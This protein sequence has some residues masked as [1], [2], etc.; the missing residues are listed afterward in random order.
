MGHHHRRN[1]NQER[2]E[3]DVA[4]NTNNNPIG[5]MDISS[6]LGNLNLD[7]IDLSKIDMNKVQSMMDKI[8]I[9]KSTPEAPSGSPGTGID[10]R[11]NFLNSLKG[12]LPA[13]RARS[14]D[15][16][17]KFF[18]IAQLFSNTKGAKP[19]LSKHK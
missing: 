16:I 9:P 1:R 7:N 3:N 8:S 6:M 13:R 17:T 10:P 15:S 19:N 18:T 14:M 5:N 11:M 4:Q 2:P 12:I